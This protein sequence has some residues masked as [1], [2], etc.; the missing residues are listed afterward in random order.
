MLTTINILL[1]SRDK[2]RLMSRI[3][4][5]SIKNPAHFRSAFHLQSSSVVRSGQFPHQSGHFVLYTLYTSKMPTTFYPLGDLFLI[6]LRLRA[7]F[8][9]TCPGFSLSWLNSY[10]KSIV[11]KPAAST[12]TLLP[13]LRRDWCLGLGSVLVLVW[14]SAFCCIFWN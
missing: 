2:P 11:S 8:S 12:P 1:H 13:T 9:S 10:P 5:N 7:D 3:L 4:C 6:S 14:A